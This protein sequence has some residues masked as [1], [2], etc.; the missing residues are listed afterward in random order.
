MSLSGTA[1]VADYQSAMRTVTYHSTSEDPTGTSA[2]RTITW[3]DRRRFDGVGAKTGTI[4]SSIT[5][6]AV[7]ETP[8]TGGDL[9][10]TVAASGSA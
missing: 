2:T 8:E 6:T 4:T 1:T 7:N 10:A 3:C 9:G 5:L